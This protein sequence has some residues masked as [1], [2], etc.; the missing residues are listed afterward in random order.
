M[1]SASLTLW[2]FLRDISFCI[3][4]LGLCKLALGIVTEMYHDTSP[5]V[6]ATRLKI[7]LLKM[8]SR[9]L[10]F[11]TYEN[12]RGYSSRY[13]GEMYRGVSYRMVSPGSNSKHIEYV[14]MKTNH[15]RNT[16][17]GLFF[18]S[19]LSLSFAFFFIS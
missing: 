15:Y 19:P 16:A 3:L 13:P 4:L 5:G 12:T 17:L 7:N 14:K 11:N 8:S 9:I 1:R 6:S 10:L 18:L 2:F